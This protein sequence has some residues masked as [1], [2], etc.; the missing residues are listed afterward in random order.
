MIRRLQLLAFAFAF[1]MQGAWSSLGGADL[2]AN[3]SGAV[4]WYDTLGFP[5]ARDLLYVRVATGSWIK[6]GNN[7][8]DNRF[9]EGFLVSE[10]ADAFR[11][12][13]CSVSDFKDPYGTSEPHAPLTTVRF[14]RKNTGPAY[15]HVGYE[16]LDFDKASS[17]ALDRVRRQS[18]KTGGRLA[19]GRPVSH[20]ARIFSFARACLQ[21]GRS[22]TAS[23]LMGFAANIPE[24]QTGKTEPQRL[25]EFLQQDFGEAVLLK[26]ERDCGNPS[27]SWAELL[28]VYGE[29]AKRYPA[30][31]KVGYAKEAAELLR[32]MIDEEG[33]HHPKPPD[34]MSAAEQVA[35]NIYQLRY[36]TG[37]MW[38]VNSHYPIDA[39][40]HEG[41]AA[42]RPA[43]RLVDLGRAAVPQ[44]IEALDDRRF[45]RCM[46]MQFNGV[47][48]PSVM[49]VSNVA[50][51]ILEHISGRNLFA[52][53]TEQGK[54]AG[55]TTRQLAEAWWAEVQGK[56]EKEVLINTA[57]SGGQE[58]CAAAR[59]LVEKYPEAAIE[60]IEAGI[61]ATKEGGYRGEYVEVAGTL[62]GDAPVAF[63]RSKLG[64]GNGLYSQMHAAE[65]LLARGKSEAVPA[66]IE[67]WHAVQSRLPTNEGDAY[68]EV[69]GLIAFLAESG[70]ERAI[71][72]LG[73]DLGKAPIDVRLA[74][75]E[76]FLPFGQSGG[77]S[78]IGMSVTASGST[79]RDTPNLPDEATNAA[80][81]RLL[82]SELDDAERRFG[83]ERDF[84]GVSVTDPRACDTAAFVLS[85]LWP[86]K[87][88]FRWALTSTKCDA[89][90]AGIRN[91]WRSD[92]GLPVLQPPTHVVMPTAKKQ[93]VDPLLDQFASATDDAGRGAVKAK[94]A[95]A[96][97]LGALPAVR[98]RFEESKNAAFRGL[99]VNL[100][101]RVREVRIEADAGESAEKSGIASLQ[102]QSLAGGC[103]YQLANELEST[104]PAGV[105]SVTFFAERA[106]D[107]EGFKV[108]V[109]WIAGG[110]KRQNGW[111]RL[112]AVRS[113]NQRLYDGN[114]YASMDGI[115]NAE[116][117]RGM[118]DAFEKAIQSEIDAPV[119]ARIRIERS[120]SP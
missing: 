40:T 69:G 6:S 58:G 34:R 83:M 24:E 15:E 32:K 47:F 89:Q 33:A 37:A 10:E 68:S 106:G 90:I 65:A 2:P 103:L 118:G 120:G 92:H 19:W 61:R 81:E 8:P 74:A 36:L 16:V 29:F 88:R 51:K 85:V 22:E 105:H 52:R 31:P 66:M 38:I 95:E 17:D 64:P 109:A 62:P 110:I 79:P 70:S 11:V 46:E 112:M 73:R 9:A 44:L 102:G 28:K 45:T 96:F 113:G 3:V 21:K 72:A 115:P 57:V 97:G 20:R 93:D 63:L 87:Y 78:S 25:N 114:G 107:G 111:D 50:Q 76:V 4:S 71:D 108:T 1:A 100:A 14:V 48:P 35:E 13:I 82:V 55:A 84:G 77:G 42:I 98:A 117:Y 75:V 119:T 99:A 53:R 91:R 27:I 5:D 60:A 12:F 7:P 116:I 30:S 67:A 86:E 101:S 41:K 59:K 54:L 26:A 49:R 18:A 94:I 43:L 23:A 39:W 104:L 56:G 80:V